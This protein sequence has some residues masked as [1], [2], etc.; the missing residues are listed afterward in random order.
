[1]SIL[2]DVPIVL[3]IDIILKDHASDETV[4]GKKEED[5]LKENEVPD[6]LEKKVK[7]A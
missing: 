5:T 1:M 6:F 2:K 7:S 4:K 3:N